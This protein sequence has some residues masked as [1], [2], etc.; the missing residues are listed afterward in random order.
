MLMW[1]KVD[2]DV[3]PISMTEEIPGPEDMKELMSDIASDHLLVRATYSKEA[4][5]NSKSILGTNVMVAAG[6]KDT[7]SNDE[8][9]S[10]GF[11]K[12][13]SSRDIQGK[14]DGLKIFMNN[15]WKRLKRLQIWVPFQLGI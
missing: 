15:V 13:E 8:I 12:H 5:D 3:F 6:H 7:R 9:A 11:E 1:V 4:V 14:N 10:D 2:K